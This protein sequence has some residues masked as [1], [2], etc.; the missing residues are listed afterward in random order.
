MATTQTAEY[1]AFGPWV[2]DVS[3][4]DG[5]PRLY[6]DFPLDF[7]KTELVLKVPRNIPRRDARP[8]MDLYDALL[9]VDAAATTVL[10]RAGGTYTT[11][12]VPHTSLVAVVDSVLLLDGRLTLHVHD[13]EPVELA[14]NGSSQGVMSRLVTVLRRLAP[15]DRGGSSA[16]IP[17]PTGDL[18][19]LD[20]E[21]DYA[22]AGAW[23]ELARR[24]PAVALAG[25]HGSTPLTPGNGL[26][27]RIVNRLRPRMV[28][29]AIVATSPDGIHVLHRRKAVDSGKA[30][31]LSLVHT[32]LFRR[33][34]A[35][36]E[37]RDHPDLAGMRIV[38]I[39]DGDAALQFVVPRDSAT[40]AAFRRT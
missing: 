18:A 5:V 33:P 39:A 25:A 20:G 40:V 26:V 6:R 8:D 30:T 3:D 21:R 4:A 36:I 28:T 9:I 16:P 31:D 38:G 13:G 2:D 15:A 22:L 17:L 10:S 1:A 12:S 19:A 35:R 14:Y 11:R 7:A 29:A 23:R 32:F 24:E 34:T 27:A 37:H